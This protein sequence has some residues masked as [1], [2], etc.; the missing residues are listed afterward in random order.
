MRERISKWRTNRRE[1][2]QG[3]DE[4]TQAAMRLLAVGVGIILTGFVI[5][6]LLDPHEGD[7]FSLRQLLSD[8]YANGGAELLSIAVTVLIIERLNRRRAE[9]ER[10]EELI[11]Q[12]GSPDNAFAVEAVR[13]LRQKG[14]LEDGSLTG[15]NLSNARLEYAVLW[16][17]SLVSMNLWNA[18]L[19]GANLW[20]ANL[21]ASILWQA[22]LAAANLWEANLQKAQLQ[23]ANLQGSYLREA[24]LR[25]A[26]LLEANLEAVR[27][28]NDS[29]DC[30]LP[31]CDETTILPD[32]TRWTPDRDWRE[33][34]HPKEWAAEQAK[35]RFTFSKSPGFARGDDSISGSKPNAAQKPETAEEVGDEPL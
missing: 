16:Q 7:E 24:N 6:Y 25:G 13:I 19:L 18:N 8:L 3:L 12:M 35:K 10:K 23:G 4:A 33:F 26:N 15:E 32:G 17:A 34:T 28:K 31:I 21:Q 20:R 22:T 5:L 27:F 2:W 9:Q 11:L 1:Q 30:I 14:W 29:Y